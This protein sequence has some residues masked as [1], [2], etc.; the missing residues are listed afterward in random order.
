MKTKGQALDTFK[1][2]KALVENQTGKTIKT[3]QDNKGGEY[4]SKEFD[5]LTASSGIFRQR[6]ALATPQQNGLAEHFNCTLEEGIIAMLH[7]A[8]L[9]LT[10]WGEAAM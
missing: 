2:Y 10:F 4:T 9:P 3:L 7:D 5:A 1:Q 8:H 6:T